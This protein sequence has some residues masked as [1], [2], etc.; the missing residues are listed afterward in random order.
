[1][2][3]KFWSGIKIFC[4][5]NFVSVDITKLKGDYIL[6]N[7]TDLLSVFFNVTQQTPYSMPKIKEKPQFK[8][9]FIE[10]QFER[11]SKKKEY[12]AIGYREIKK[13]ETKGTIHTI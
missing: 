6:V 10:I 9:K 13:V 7:K 12:R 3:K 2:G 8:G 4:P 11:I 5:G 1:M